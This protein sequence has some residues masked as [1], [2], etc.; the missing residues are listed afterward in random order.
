MNFSKA[1]S[2]ALVIYIDNY[3]MG[4]VLFIKAINFMIF[5]VKN[6]PLL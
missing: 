4:T 6:L 5:E 1:K 2:L 3:F